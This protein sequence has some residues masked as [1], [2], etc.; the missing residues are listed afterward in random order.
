MP[1]TVF[2]PPDR[3]VAGTV[4]PPG[5][6]TFFLQAS[7]EGRT[8]SVS[9][10]KVQVSVLADRVGDLLDAHAEGTATEPLDDGDTEPLETPIEDDFRVDT[11]SLAW[12]PERHVLVIECH[13]QDPEEV[14][15]STLST[16]RVVLTPQ[17]ARAF[18]R[19]CGRV[20]AAGRPPC[21]FCGQPLDPSGHICPRANG[22][23]R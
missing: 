9:L 20:V 2:D 22:Y 10:E 13:D 6:R 11:L 8:V 12:D 1:A 21:P 4:G 18:A 14:E 7:G 16:L 19:R 3:F 23:R 15:E 5:G 17:A